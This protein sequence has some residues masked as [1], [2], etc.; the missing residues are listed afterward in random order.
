LSAVVLPTKISDFMYLGFL[1]CIQRKEVV[2]FTPK[3]SD[4][5]AAGLN[6][7]QKQFYSFQIT[8]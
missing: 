8:L 5:L 4:L 6:G 1:I 2:I 3:D 7:I